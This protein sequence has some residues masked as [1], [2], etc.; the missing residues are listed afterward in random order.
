MSQR[1]GCSRKGLPPLPFWDLFGG[2]FLRMGKRG[3]GWVEW[4]GG[5]GTGGRGFRPPDCWSPRCQERE[6][7]IRNIRGLDGFFVARSEA[8]P[9]AFLL[10]VIQS[11][12]CTAPRF[13]IPGD[14]SPVV[15]ISTSIQG[16]RDERLSGFFEGESKSS[17]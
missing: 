5:L 2:S 12:M 10:V 15:A 13:C 8:D 16:P 3:L 1:N 17:R 6:G 7:K 14:W 4:W 9:A 11:C